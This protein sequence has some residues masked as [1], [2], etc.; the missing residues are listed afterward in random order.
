MMIRRVVSAYLA[1]K[2]RVPKVP[3]R[4][5]NKIVSWAS[6]YTESGGK[7]PTEREFEIRQEDLSYGTLRSSPLKFTVELEQGGDSA[8]GSFSWPHKTLTL[9]VGMSSRQGFASVVRHE[10]MHLLQFATREAIGQGVAFGE[11]KTEWISGANDYYYQGELEYK[12]QLDTNVQDF[13]DI[14]GHFD[15]NELTTRDTDGKSFF[16]D[17][18]DN[19][20]F[21]RALKGLGSS[22]RMVRDGFGWTWGKVEI[23]DKGKPVR[24]EKAVRD[25]Y[26]MLSRKFDRVS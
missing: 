4:L 8:Y 11:P 21:F 26:L 16:E 25:F 18:V 19:S 3:E 5:I 20:P 6:V 10:L 14:Y 22:K 2:A 13:Y 12:P 15:F 17:W 9:N 23:K 7:L 24:Y 1:K